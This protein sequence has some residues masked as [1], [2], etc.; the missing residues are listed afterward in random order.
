[1]SDPQVPNDEIPT[2]EMV[3]AENPGD[4][5]REQ[6]KENDRLLREGD[7]DTPEDTVPRT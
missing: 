6:L 5:A 7:E 3:T 4:E 2:D 1:M